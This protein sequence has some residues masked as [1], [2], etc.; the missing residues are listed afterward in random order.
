MEAAS[1]DRRGAGWPAPLRWARRRHRRTPV[2]LLVVS[3]AIA[4]L[5]LAPVGFLLDQT[6]SNSWEEVRRLLFRPFVGTLLVNTTTL[7]A[8]G[9]AA[10]TV[11]G[12]AVAWLVERT[13]LPGRRAWA[14]LAALPITVPAF[15]TSYSWVSI[16]PAVQGFWG[17]AAIVTLAYYPLV[18]LPVAA[19]LRGTDPAL[20]ES[21][22]SLGMGP[23]RTFFRVTLPQT[24][25]ALLGGMLLVSVHML[26]EFGAFAML[27]F[28]TFT[29][30]IYDE[31]KLSFDGAAASM[32][33]SVLV[34]LCL[35]LLVAEL[36]ARG[37]GRYARVDSGAARPAPPARLG[38][39]R[40]PVSGGFLGLIGLALGLPLGTLVYWV[41][42]GSS[43]AE[44]DLGA[45]LSATGTSLQLGLGA[46]ALTTL[47]ALPISLLAVRHPSR[48]ATVI[49]RATYIPFALPGI[50]VALSLIVL[51][52]H[53]FPAIYG[54][55]PLLI[56][57]YAILSLPLALVA[58][59][60]A[61]AQAPPIDEEVARSL[62]CGPLQAMFR[63]TLPRILPGL[64][65]AAALVFLATVTE[66]TATLLLAPIGTQTLA[67]QFWA[68]ASSLSYGAAAPYAALMV[69]ISALPTY[70]LTRRLGGVVQPAEAR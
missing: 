68:S 60:A 3:A 24:R 26:A 45:L 69:A 12:V 28:Q 55:T 34:L 53:H 37:R 32:L 1:V 14:V 52:I 43:A 33:A 2:A 70:L 7:V 27:R 47:L 54:S 22:R 9:T 67:T 51:S 56:V 65:A 21:A 40:W 4:L 64:G 25:V 29:T 11:L 5:V 10:C 42:T 35:V 41:A 58:V 59:R 16:T 50:V 19:V 49:E 36:G 38:R 61:L 8:A 48:A 39:W 46:A 44:I 13:D 31:Y 62:G 57:A 30:A 66:L 20:E 17:A 6:F 18:Y 63:V 23:W 15:V